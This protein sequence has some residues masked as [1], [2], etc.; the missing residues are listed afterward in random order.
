MDCL[1]CKIVK[2]VV[3]SH[4]IYE[5]DN[6][7][8]FLDV[9]PVTNGHTVV[10]PKKHYNTFTQMSEEEAAILFASVNKITKAIEKAFNLNGLNVGM[11]IGEVAGQS[12]H[13]IHVHI[14]PRTLEDNGGSMH[15]IVCNKNIESFEENVNRIKEAF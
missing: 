10:I 1:F 3:P 8:A 9:Y 7:F 13:H 11:N 14:I 15:T 6:V 5:D 2:G 12:I 4:K